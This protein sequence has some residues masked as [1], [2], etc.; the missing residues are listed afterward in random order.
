MT[1]T[2][3]RMST[4][5]LARRVTSLVLLALLV[6]P[7]LASASTPP[8]RPAFVYLALGDSLAV[9]V[10]A[11]AP[12]QFGYVPRLFEFFSRPRHGKVTTLRNLGVAGETTTS[13]CGGDCSA[14]LTGQV[15]TG[16]LAEAL[17]VI[18]DRRTNIR[19]VTLD[20][21]G[22]DLLHLLQ[23]GQPCASPGDPTCA[24]AVA[25]A[26]EQVTANYPVILEALT[27]A[28]AEDPGHERILVMTYYNAFSGT[29][30]PYDALTR[31]ALLGADGTLDCTAHDA[32]VGLNDLIACISATYDVRVVDTYPLFEGRT[33]ALT[34]IA[35]G[36]VHPNDAGY[37]VIADAFQRATKHHG[38]GLP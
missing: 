14:V 5:T 36:D 16:Q 6:T 22:N 7:A 17:R 23:P 34:H 33:L 8:L 21:G 3:R 11:S 15:Q 29:G 9:G 26:L 1:T 2:I 13:M 38:G 28:L 25:Q 4:T 24:A 37:A 30:S 10:G 19:V 31:R 12:D 20:I 18:G 27:A 32:D 35:G